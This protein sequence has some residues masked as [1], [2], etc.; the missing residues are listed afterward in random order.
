[1]IIKKDLEKLI[2]GEIVETVAYVKSYD[3]RPAKNNNKFIDGMLE[4]KGSVPFKVWSGATFDELEKYD[5]RSQVC[6]ITAKVNE[7]NGSKSLIINSVKAIAEGTYDPSDFFEEKYQINAY[8]DALNKLIQKNCSDIGVQIFNKVFSDIEDRFKV[9]FAARGHHDA[10]RGGLLAHTYKMSFIMSRV[11]KMYPNILNALDNDL[12]VLGA[13]LHDIGKIIEYTNGVI[14]GNGLIVSH[15]SFGVEMLAKHKDFIVGL[16]NEDFYYRLIAIITQ[17][18]GQYGEPPRCVEAYLVHMVD[19][20][21]STFQSID[22]GYEKGL[23][24]INVR[25]YKLN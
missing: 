20:L 22:E 18:H 5:Y 24:T 14:E 17:H 6:F 15:C 23:K 11:I 7:F 9:E 16:K 3:V 4:M 13:S 12:F 25:E 21:E 19:S 8:W 1:M 2:D 10:V